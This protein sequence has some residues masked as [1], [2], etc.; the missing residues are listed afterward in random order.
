M[1][2]QRRQRRKRC[3]VH[4]FLAVKFELHVFRSRYQR[5][6]HS[7]V[8]TR[9][10]NRKTARLA[11]FAYQK[12]QRFLI[13]DQCVCLFGAQLAVKPRLHGVRDC[14]APTR[15]RLVRVLR[16]DSR[17]SL[18]SRQRAELLLLWLTSHARRAA[19]RLL[20]RL[21]GARRPFSFA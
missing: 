12:R 2:N 1:I 19:W 17:C 21:I 10:S 6:A 13:F 3:Y 7:A 14:A 9:A 5:V 8:L 16:G 15:Q 4:R 11:R 20:K 18:L